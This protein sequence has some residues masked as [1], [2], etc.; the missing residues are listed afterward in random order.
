MHV[1]FPELTELRLFPDAEALPVVPDSFLDRSAPRLRIFQL[2]A[3][4]IPGLSRLLL[5]ATHLVELLLTNIPHSG[6]KLS[7]LSSPCC[8]ASEHLTLISNPLNLALAGK[9]DVR[10]HQNV[11]S[12]P[13]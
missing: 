6:Y 1:P 12:S 9:A 13:L 5:S 10:L 3:I 11:L 7:S 4:P 8:P 2:D